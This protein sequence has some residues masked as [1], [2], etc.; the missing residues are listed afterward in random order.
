M[1]AFEPGALFEAGAQMSFA[2]SA[3]ILA[4]LGAGRPVIPDG[5]DRPARST[6]IDALL[7]TSAAAIAATAPLAAM[8]FGRVAPVG[9]LANL[10]AIPATAALLL[11]ASLLA[12][13]ATLLRPD[14]PLTAFVVSVCATVAS[15]ALS[16]AE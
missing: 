6:C 5:R 16:G 8:H 9:V 13:S 14:A 1:L 10:V 12:A 4:G 7:R 15:A 3:A 2:A 11:P